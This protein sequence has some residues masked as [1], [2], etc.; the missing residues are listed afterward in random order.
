MDAVNS[1]RARLRKYPVLV[2]QCRKT[3]TAYARC[4]IKSSNIKKDD[5]KSEFENFK[6]CLV[7]AAMKNKTRL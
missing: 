6:N 5:C 3:G 7:N 4:V 2:A 1:A